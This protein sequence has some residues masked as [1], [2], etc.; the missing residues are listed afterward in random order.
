MVS[1]TTKKAIKDKRGLHKFIDHC[2]Q[3]F[4]YSFQVKKCG[5]AECTICKPVRMDP[6]AF[7]SLHFLPNPVPGLDDHY[8]QSDHF[9][10]AQTKPSTEEAE[11]NLIF[12]KSAARKERRNAVAM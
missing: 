7:A 2:C 6:V 11:I 10:Q 3:A 4:H 8:G 5:M 9:R 1:D 12:S